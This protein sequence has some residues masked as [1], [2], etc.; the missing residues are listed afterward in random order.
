MDWLHI[1][2][3]CI[4][5][6]LLAAVVVLS[7]CLRRARR[8]LTLIGDAFADMKAGNRFRLV[9]ADGSEQSRKILSDINDI[10]LDHRSK[11][12]HKEQAAQTLRLEKCDLCGLTRSVL[13]ECRPLL[14]GS[15]LLLEE[16]IPQAALPVL[17]DR[18]AYARALT[19]L[20]QSVTLR[21]GAKEV[22]LSV[23]A[24]GKRAVVLVMD[25]GKPI[26][27]EDLPYLFEQSDA[28]DGGLNAVRVLV[29]RQRGTLGA[30]STPEEGTCF[31]M[32]YPM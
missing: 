22:R 1:L 18:A 26:A 11:L 15:G 13:S 17:I 21:G 4:T 5:L 16:E 14:E 28:P 19:S 25:D 10:L 32:T 12:L 2:L 29:E 24:Q 9:G 31:T 30:K 27:Q 20:L 23:R 6:L 8:Q 3:L 7:I